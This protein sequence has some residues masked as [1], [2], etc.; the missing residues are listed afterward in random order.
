VAFN[1]GIGI[2]V[3]VTKYLTVFGE[4]RDYIYLE[5]L[6]NLEVSLG[7]DREDEATWIDEN[8]TLTNNMSVHLGVTLFFPFGFE[9]RY[10]K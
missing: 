1:A 6:E 9:Y 5:K 2:R 3:F 7:A 8:A 4:F 10:P